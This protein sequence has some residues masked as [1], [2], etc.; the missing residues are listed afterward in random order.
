MSFR[1]YSVELRIRLPARQ[2]RQH[3]TRARS[4]PPVPNPD[5]DKKK[6]PA[7]WR[8][9]LVPGSCCR[10]RHPGCRLRCGEVAEMRRRVRTEGGRSKQQ[11]LP[12]T[13][14]CEV[15]LSPTCT[16][17]IEEVDGGTDTLLRRLRLP[18]ALDM[19]QGPDRY[20]WERLANAINDS[21][22]ESTHRRSH[23]RSSLQP[24]PVSTKSIPSHDRR[25]SRHGGETPMRANYGTYEIP[26]GG[27]NC[28]RCR[29]N[30]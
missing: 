20:E 18:D 28:V 15:R 14:D 19:G 27:T 7:S 11:P 21:T 12:G 25:E 5:A 10:G 17:T 13:P 3:L 22:N 4:V 6:P 2:Q 16:P 29:T 8:Q 1:A 24:S 9:G 30:Q 23:Q 26:F